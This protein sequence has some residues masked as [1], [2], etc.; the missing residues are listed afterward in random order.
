MLNLT[1]SV[2]GQFKY[3]HLHTI[4]VLFFV[5]NTYEMDIYTDKVS[6]MGLEGLLGDI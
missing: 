6:Y 2:I 4:E 3:S 5:K 1:G